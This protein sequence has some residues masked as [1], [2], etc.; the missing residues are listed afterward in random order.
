MK[1]TKLERKDRPKGK[2]IPKI[3]FKIKIL[4]VI[5][6]SSLRLRPLKRVRL[7]THEEEHIKF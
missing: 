5:L 2:I 1:K 4:T 6:S 7:L 3:Y